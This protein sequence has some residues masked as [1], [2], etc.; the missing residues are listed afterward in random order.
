MGLAAIIDSAVDV[1]GA[2]IAALAVS[3]IGALAVWLRSRRAKKRVAIELPLS[4]MLAGDSRF[5]FGLRH[6]RDGT[7]QAAD[8]GPLL[9]TI[10]WFEKAN[11]D[12]T[13]LVVRLRYAKRLGAQ[14]KCFADYAQM[15][16]EEAANLLGQEEVIRT[17]DR[18]EAPGSNRAWFLLTSH[19]AVT[20]S[21][22]FTNNF[23]D[24]G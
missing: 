17:I 7:D 24:P 6:I 22:E 3:A 8:H 23:I 2:V 1:L 20:T 13:R 18:E 11:G 16:F 10:H 5:R 14:F 9:N 4:R 19:R 15:P 12:G 21:D